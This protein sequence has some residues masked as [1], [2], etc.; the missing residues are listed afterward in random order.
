MH[1]VDVNSKRPERI[2]ISTVDI[3]KIIMK[4]TPLQKRVELFPNNTADYMP[5]LYK[6]MELPSYVHGYSLAI[7]YMRDWFLQSFQRIYLLRVEL[8]L[9]LFI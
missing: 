1:I 3:D 6:T 7:E 8:C 2:P 9:R 5:R 4:R